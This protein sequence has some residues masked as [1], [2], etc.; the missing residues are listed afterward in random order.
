MSNT[1]RW[2][3]NYTA[4]VQ[5]VSFKDNRKVALTINIEC[6]RKNVGLGDT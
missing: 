3:A 5:T 4:C 6:G 2:M 1:E